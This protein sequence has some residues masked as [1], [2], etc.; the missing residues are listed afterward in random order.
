[1]LHNFQQVCEV[2]GPSV[3]ALHSY[4]N[5]VSGVVSDDLHGI[6]LG[7]TLRLLHLWFD[8]ET[9]ESHT[10]KATRCEDPNRLHNTKI[11][12]FCNTFS[13]VISFFYK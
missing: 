10:S 7:V 9:E 2:K 12:P 11:M 1:M 4:F 3:L 6:Y 13:S 5:L 8:G